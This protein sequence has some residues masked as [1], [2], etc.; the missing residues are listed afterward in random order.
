M[1][2]QCA[3]VTKCRVIAHPRVTPE[4]STPHTMC[5]R[6]Y[7]T[8]WSAIT[9]IVLVCGHYAMLS[10]CVVRCYYFRINLLVLCV[11][12][13]SLFPFLPPFLLFFVC[14]FSAS[15]RGLVWSS[16]RFS[17]ALGSESQGNGSKRG[18]IDIGKR[19]PELTTEPHHTTGVGY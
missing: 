5:A 13:F 7:Y 17:F 1:P 15:H 10:V 4:S 18:R 6:P 12:V 9:Q 8:R 2:M 3:F 11:F 19:M 14:P 16:H